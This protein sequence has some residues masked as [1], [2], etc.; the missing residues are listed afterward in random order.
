MVLNIPGGVV[1]AV[2]VLSVGNIG[3]RARNCVGLLSIIS[4][5]M[6]VVGAILLWVAPPTNEAALFVGIY[7]M[8][9]T[10]HVC[11]GTEVVDHRALCR[12]SS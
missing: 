2:I 6:V 7:F 4:Q 12:H 5:L 10:F 1:S 9:S 8:V 11:Y 3:V